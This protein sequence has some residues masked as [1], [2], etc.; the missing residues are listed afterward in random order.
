MN[1]TV[2]KTTRERFI[3]VAPLPPSVNS[4]YQNRKPSSATK[5]QK[6][7]RLTDEARVYK[8]SVTYLVKNK[9]QLEEMPKPPYVVFYHFRFPDRRKRDIT[10]YVKILEDAVFAGMHIDDRYV[11]AVQIFKYIAK[12]D[13]GAVVEVRHCTR[14][15]EV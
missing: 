2:E 10:N 6:G 3:V 13:P 15:I 7:R 8:D 14:D 1:T 11:N 5:K 12:G 4:A 9:C